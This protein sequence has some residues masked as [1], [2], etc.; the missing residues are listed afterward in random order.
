MNIN[1][2]VHRVYRRRSVG[3]SQWLKINVPSLSITMLLTG[4]SFNDDW[5]LSV[6]LSAGN[7]SMT[8]LS[9]KKVP[10]DWNKFHL[11][12]LESI[13]FKKN[14]RKEF[15][16]LLAQDFWLYFLPRAADENTAGFRLTSSIKIQNLGNS[17]SALTSWKWERP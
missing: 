8:W 16:H 2:A 10:W 3:R 7:Q 11:Q 13:N 17:V 5:A 1:K 14:S 4:F 12:Y 6:I 15:F 9:I